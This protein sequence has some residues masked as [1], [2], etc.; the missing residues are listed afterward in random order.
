MPPAFEKGN[1]PK[2]EEWNY[3]GESTNGC[4]W[5]YQT[6]LKA[7][8]TGFR[9]WTNTQ[10]EKSQ[11][12]SNDKKSFEYTSYS[13]KYYISCN[14]E[15]VWEEYSEYYD[16]N[17]SVVHT[18]EPEIFGIRVQ[19]PDMES[20]GLSGSVIGQNSLLRIVYKLGCS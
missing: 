16:K 1:A 20:Q 6:P 7:A 18:F 2:K 4:K 17:G 19:G 9:F 8:G 15:K 11:T 3:L 10:C 12:A 5:N 13:S 14:K